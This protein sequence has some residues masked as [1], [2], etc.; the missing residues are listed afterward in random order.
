M[1][2][3]QKQNHVRLCNVYFVYDFNEDSFIL[4]RLGTNIFQVFT[5]KASKTLTFPISHD[6]ASLGLCYRE[7]TLIISDPIL[8]ITTL[9]VRCRIN[10]AY[11]PKNINARSN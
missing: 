3:Y 5:S 7:A 6:Q 1:I 8:T 2:H 9:I 10:A 11:C 4:Q